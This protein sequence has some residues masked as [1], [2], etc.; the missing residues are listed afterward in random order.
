MIFACNFP[1]GWQVCSLKKVYSQPSKS[2]GS[3]SADSTTY[4]LKLFREK[5]FQKISE[6]KLEF[7]VYGQLQAYLG[8]IE[9]LAPDHCGKVNIVIQWVIQSFC[10]PSAY[11][12]YVYTVL[13]SVQCPIASCLKKQCLCLKVTILYWDFSGVQWLRLHLPVQGCGFS[14]WVES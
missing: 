12:N 3:V 9:D 7:V 11:K 1:L 10:L 2:A 13:S 14:P 5:I 4:R 8:S 6:A